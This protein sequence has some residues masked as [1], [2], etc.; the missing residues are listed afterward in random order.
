MAAARS[1]WHAVVQV[2]RS[3]RE[4]AAT[5]PLELRLTRVM[6]PGPEGWLALGAAA[7]RL[8]LELVREGQPLT[9]V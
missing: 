3:R 6:P 1:G 2:V 5:E 4:P 7:P 9:G 8:N